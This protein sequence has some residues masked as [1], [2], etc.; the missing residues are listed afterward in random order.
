MSTISN[1]VGTQEAETHE[2][3]DH[4]TRTSDVPNAEPVIEGLPETDIDRSREGLDD[5][6][7]DGRRRPSHLLGWL[8]VAG[9]IVASVVV[10]LLVLA[11]DQS[12]RV[13]IPDAKDNPNYGPVVVPPVLGD[14]EDNPNFGPV[15]AP[16][17]IGDAKDHPGYGVSL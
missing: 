6:R 3:L 1:E 5:R 16:T 7:H 4:Q 11:D 15:A 13:P 12:T 10:A 14:A 2:A 9:A 17:T 8:L